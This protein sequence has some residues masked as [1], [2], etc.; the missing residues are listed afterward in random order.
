M[1][2]RN[3]GN[4]VFGFWKYEPNNDVCS[5]KCLRDLI[6]TGKIKSLKPYTGYP[7]L[8]ISPPNKRSYNM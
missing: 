4:E 1:K 7:E 2:C 5:K 8:H 6:S 3:C